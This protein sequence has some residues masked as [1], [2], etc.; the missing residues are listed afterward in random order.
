MT[1]SEIDFFKTLMKTLFH[2][3]MKNKC[4]NVSVRSIKNLEDSSTLHSFK[5]EWWGGYH[6]KSVKPP[7]GISIHHFGF[8]VDGKIT[9]KEIW[10][11]N[12]SG[13]LTLD[14]G[15]YFDSM[16]ESDHVC[17]LQGFLSPKCKID[18]KR[19]FSSIKMQMLE[20]I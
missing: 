4:I 16:F 8:H 10:F 13:E 19:L 15:Q 1:S 14:I 9:C 12:Y 18:S 2:I 7:Y 5:F 17:G 20:I 3:G 6:L 11:Y